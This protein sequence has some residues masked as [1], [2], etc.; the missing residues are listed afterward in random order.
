MSKINGGD[1]IVGLTNL[2]GYPEIKSDIKIKR[3]FPGDKKTIMS[4]IKENFQENWAYEAEHSIMQSPGKC[5]IA[6]EEGQ[7]IGFACYD[8]SAKGFF[9]PIGVLPNKRKN[10]VGEALLLRTLNAMSEYG[11]GYVI[12]GWVSEAEMFYRKTVKAE[13]I[14]GG[15]PKNSVYANL[16]FMK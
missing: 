8:A 2:P 4:F 13:Y 15:Q 16:I 6:T 11:C 1:M 10:K 3:A 5:F 14:K 9:G 7:L 12:I